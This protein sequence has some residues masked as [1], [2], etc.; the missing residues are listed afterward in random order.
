M[1]ENKNIEKLKLVTPEFRVSHPHLFK[2]NAMKGS[3]KKSYSIE[4][5]FDKTTTDIK[6]LQAPLIEAAKEKWGPDKNDW[7]KPLKLA[8]RDGDKPYGKNKEVKKEHK[9]MWVMKASSSAEFSRPHVVDKDPKIAITEE[10]KIYPGC[11][12]RAHLKAHAYTFADKDG[13]KYILDA[14]QFI[15]DGVAIG[16]KKPADQMF[17]VIEGL[18]DES[19]VDSPFGSDEENSEES[20]L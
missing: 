10:G 7:P 4:M 5:L 17:G 1:S 8:Y 19:D 14:V 15:R 3:E 13:V 12:A 9:G 16:G 11:Y 6:V 20:F 2:P 18:E